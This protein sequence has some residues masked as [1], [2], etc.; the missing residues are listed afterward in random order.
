M[1]RSRID[2]ARQFLRS[3]LLGLVAIFIV[4]GGTAIAL[5]GKNR[6]DSGDIKQGAVRTL[7]LRREA[8]TKTKLR[9]NAVDGTRVR[10]NSLTDDDINESTL[11]L[12]RPLKVGSVGEREE[13]DRERRIVLGAG[14]LVPAIANDP[15]VFQQFGLPVMQ[16]SG[17]E[18]K[19]AGAMTEVPLD[20][21][22]G[23][24]LQ[25]RLLW[26]AP[27]GTGDVLWNVGFRTIG[28]G[29]TGL[30]SG[31]PAGPDVLANASAA[32]TAI[33]TTALTVPATVVDNGEPLTLQI[34][35]DGDAPQDT[36]GNAFLHLVEIR[37]TATG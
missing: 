18:E 17:S 23:S 12:D 14:E 11:D 13:A 19:F 16:F 2:S 4:L 24:T 27:S 28:P 20:R 10:N 3:N 25:V 26:S 9:R 37:Y 22:P 35:R 21:A 30:D 29:T 8:V 31:V 36:L 5:P 33:E 32:S 1:P 34:V 15:P 7:D 6:V